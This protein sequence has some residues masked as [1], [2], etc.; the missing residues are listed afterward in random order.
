MGHAINACPSRGI[1][2]KPEDIVFTKA[3][4]NWVHHPYKDFLVVMAKVANSFVHK[5]LVDNGSVFNILYWDA[6]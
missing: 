1:I 2:S 6:H 5:I 4:A 3:D